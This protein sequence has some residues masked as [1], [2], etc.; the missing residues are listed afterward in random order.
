[1]TPA[2]IPDENIV[3]VPRDPD[4]LNEA[5]IRRDS[6]RPNNREGIVGNPSGFKP[7]GGIGQQGARI[8]EMP[9]PKRTPKE[10]EEAA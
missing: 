2:K 3:A 7:L 9:T 8:I 5:M 4:L 6:F 1:M 10:K